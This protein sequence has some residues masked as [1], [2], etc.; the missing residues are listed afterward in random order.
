MLANI[1]D[2][3]YVNGV[4]NEKLLTAAVKKGWITQEHADRII[5][6]HKAQTV[7]E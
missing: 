4:L 1:L 7:E 6:E 5:A 3:M 2:R